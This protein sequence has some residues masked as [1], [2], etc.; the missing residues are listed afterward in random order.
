MIH[1]ESIDIAIKFK[2]FDFSN[3]VFVNGRRDCIGE[4]A[5]DSQSNGD[6]HPRDEMHQR[7]AREILLP[8]VQQIHV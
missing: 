2:N 8:R 3:W 4:F 1:I 7:F 5:W 6:A